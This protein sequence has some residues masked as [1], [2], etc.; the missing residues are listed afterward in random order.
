MNE[1]NLEKRKQELIAEFKGF[2]ESDDPTHQLISTEFQ[3][4]SIR[5]AEEKIEANGRSLS[6][7]EDLTENQMDFINRRTNKEEHCYY[8]RLGDKDGVTVY[9][10]NLVTQTVEANVIYDLS[11]E[12]KLINFKVDGLP[13][14]FPFDKLS[15]FIY[16]HLNDEQEKYVFMSKMSEMVKR[17]KE[18]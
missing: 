16:S 14:D 1:K 17:I 8:L 18:D 13:S 10:I 7:Y 5:L 6:E 3:K 9:V 4:K 12:I 11:D 15:D 2:E